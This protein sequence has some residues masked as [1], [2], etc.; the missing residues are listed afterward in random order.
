MDLKSQRRL[1]AK[2][3][4]VGEKRVWIDPEKID[5]VETAITR[6]EIK[7][8]IHE[9]SIKRKPEKGVSRSRARAY[10]L[11]RKKGL[12]KGQGKR[13]KSR[14][15]RKETW[16]KKIRA[17]RRKLRELKQKR[18]ITESTYRQFY[19]MASSGIFESKAE[20]EHRIKAKGLWRTR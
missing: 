19:R 10:H 14:I 9:R 6:E 1:A 18:V 15:S 17:L 12:R 7:K 3:L 4:K 16:M 2:I 8:L 13:S 5:E 11:Q 20:L